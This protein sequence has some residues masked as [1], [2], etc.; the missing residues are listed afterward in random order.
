[1]TI[2]VKKLIIMNIL[3]ILRRYSDEDHRLSQQD[4]IC[5]AEVELLAYLP[6]DATH[7]IAKLADILT[8]QH[9]Y[10]NHVYTLAFR[11]STC[12][13]HYLTSSLFDQL[14]TGN[15]FVKYHIRDL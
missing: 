1:M 9:T 5:I 12:G 13:N 11:C 2:P 15:S 14:L 10:L 7:L 3:D 8:C 4:V 6:A